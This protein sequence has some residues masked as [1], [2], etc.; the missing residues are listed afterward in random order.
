MDETICNVL[1]VRSLYRTHNAAFLCSLGD[2]LSTSSI[3]SNNESEYK[4]VKINGIRAA[5]VIGQ[6][7]KRQRYLR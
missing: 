6:M 4:R 5:L 1:L 2:T 7:L 3:V